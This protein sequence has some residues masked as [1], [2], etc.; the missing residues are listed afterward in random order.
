MSEIGL[1][2][3]FDTFNTKP[4]EEIIFESQDSADS[5]LAA[6]QYHASSTCVY[7]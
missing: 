2:H 7:I 6:P 3:S 5:A 4:E 1:G